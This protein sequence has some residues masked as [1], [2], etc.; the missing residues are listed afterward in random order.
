MAT[1][2]ASATADAARIIPYVWS[3]GAYFSD[4]TNVEHLSGGFTWDAT[5]GHLHSV[6]TRLSG[7]VS[8]S[9]TVALGSGSIGFDVTN[10]DPTSFLQIIFANDLALGRADPIAI[11]NFMATFAASAD[12]FATPG[13]GIVNLRDPEIGATEVFGSALVP[14]PA[15]LAFLCFGLAALAVGRR[16]AAR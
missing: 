11:D 14:E 3:P 12:G 2:L 1:M 8:G 13:S 7:P 9:L 4:G 10:P 15:A 6:N 16:R 5:S